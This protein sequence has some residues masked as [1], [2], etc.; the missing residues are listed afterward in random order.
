MDDRKTNIMENTMIPENYL[1][2]DSENKIYKNSIQSFA[3][4]FDIIKNYI[5]NISYAHTITYDGI[6]SLPEKFIFKLSRLLGFKLANSF[7]E[8]DFFE[9]LYEDNENT[10]NSKK[11]YNLDIWRKTLVNIVWLLK[12]KGTRESIDFV[13]N[14]IGA[15]EQLIR[16]DEY[17]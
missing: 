3:H 13:F 15:P 9:F 7:D 12:R 1:E 8:Q 2:L 10:K 17:I 5:D 6:S 14:L 11:Y 4:Q 16:F